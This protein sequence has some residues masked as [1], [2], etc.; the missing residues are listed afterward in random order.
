MLLVIDFIVGMI[1][2]NAYLNPVISYVKS[3]TS[4]RIYCD[5]VS[6]TEGSQ[7]QADSFL[8]LNVE[9]P[10]FIKASGFGI[11]ATNACNHYSVCVTRNIS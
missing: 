5:F 2:P 1:T 8:I 4:F 6:T 3:M 10:T 11:E 7:K 9:I